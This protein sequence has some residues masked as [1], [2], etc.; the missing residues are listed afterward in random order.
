MN[1]G[2]INQLLQSGLEESQHHTIWD[3]KDNISWTSDHYDTQSLK[4]SRGANTPW[5][6][7][8]YVREIIYKAME[9]NDIEL[10]PYP[11]LFQKPSSFPIINLKFQQAEKEVMPCDMSFH[12]PS[13]CLPFM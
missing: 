13:S 9:K 8:N 3:N 12:G 5:K 2:S 10:F 11:P 1:F 6:L 7:E 4:E